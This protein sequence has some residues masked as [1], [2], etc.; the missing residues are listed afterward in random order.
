MKH[1][2]VWKTKIVVVFV[3][4]WRKLTDILNIK[5]VQSRLVALYWPYRPVRWQDE[6]EGLL[7]LL[8]DPHGAMSK[9][10]V[11]SRRAA[12]ILTKNIFSGSDHSFW[13]SQPEKYI[14]LD[15]TSNDQSC[16]L[17]VGGLEFTQFLHDLILILFC[18]PSFRTNLPPGS[19]RRFQMYRPE[20][21]NCSRSTNSHEVPWPRQ[22][23]DGKSPSAPN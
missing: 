2:K 20:I 23:G 13:K 7:C 16:S 17:V 3:P 10:V 9:Q 14:S 19:Y 6:W 22:S 15:S 5:A 21:Q 18:F 8:W 11:K 4:L 1:K 12:N